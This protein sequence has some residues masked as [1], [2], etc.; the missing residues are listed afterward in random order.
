M[1][2]LV[3]S[4]YCFIITKICSIWFLEYWI[5]GKLHDLEAH[6]AFASSVLR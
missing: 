4:Y 2:N 3:G 6:D 5:N 1:Q